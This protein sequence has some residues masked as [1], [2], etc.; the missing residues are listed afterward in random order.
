MSFFTSNWSN[1]FLSDATG[2][3]MPSQNS[4]TAFSL[5][6]AKPI[7]FQVFPPSISINRVKTA[8]YWFTWLIH[9]SCFCRFFVNFFSVTWQS[10]IIMSIGSRSKCYPGK[11]RSNDWV[12]FLLELHAFPGM[13]ITHTHTH[14]HRERERE[15]ERERVFLDYQIKTL[16]SPSQRDEWW[17]SY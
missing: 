2:A 6:S 4:M 8:F 7:F 14:A 12:I 15:R 5:L 9:S 3:F 10:V 17:A 1:D 13:Q 11:I 16:Y